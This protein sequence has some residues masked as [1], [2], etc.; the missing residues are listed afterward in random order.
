[1]AG[2]P[3]SGSTLLSSILNQNENIYCSTNSPLLHLYLTTV[4]EISSCEQYRAFP[5][6]ECLN[7]VL[8]AL[9]H[10]FYQHH[11][12]SII[13]D[14]SR[15]W[16]LYVDY[17]IKRHITKDVKII[18]PVRNILDILSS[19]IN[20]IQNSKEVS[21]IDKDVTGLGWEINNKN[22]CD[23]LMSHNGAVGQYYSILRRCTILG[24]RKVLHFV[25]YDDLIRSPQNTMS[26]IYRFLD[27][28]E[29]KHDFNNIVQGEVED[30]SVYGLENMHR[31]KSHLTNNNRKYSDYLDK[32]TIEAYKNMEF[33]KERTRPPIFGLYL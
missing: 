4:T 31:I 9:P 30:D 3:R 11:Q 33:W 7:N 20:L 6:P 13:I 10:I 25:D 19:F 12:Q 8:S 26:K 28:P 24:H 29:F 21:Y 18:C 27:L 2:L 17:I 14:K 32:N 5:K 23:Y 22:R 1:M 15:S 16:P